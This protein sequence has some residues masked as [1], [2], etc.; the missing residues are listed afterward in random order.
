MIAAHPLGSSAAALCV[1]IAQSVAK[2]FIRMDPTASSRSDNSS[3]DFSPSPERGGRQSRWGPSQ[4]QSSMDG[5]YGTVVGS[6]KSL[7]VATP[8]RPAQARGC[9]QTLTSRTHE[10]GTRVLLPP[11]RKLILQVL[12]HLFPTLCSFQKPRVTRAV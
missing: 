4:E 10:R 2:T 5:E 11:H 8:I 1:A 3:S 7:E 12:S 6:G 9:A